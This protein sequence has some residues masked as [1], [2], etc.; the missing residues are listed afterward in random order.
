MVAIVV[1]IVEIQIDRG[2]EVCIS[3]PDTGMLLSAK[4]SY[5]EIIEPGAGVS[6]A[7][8]I[9]GKERSRICGSAIA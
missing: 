7:F 4:P 1:G 3:D 2:K 8:I 6:A 5:R 9:K